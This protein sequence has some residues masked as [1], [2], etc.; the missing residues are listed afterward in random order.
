M[1]IFTPLLAFLLVL[2]TTLMH[3]CLVM[4]G[5]FNPSDPHGILYAQLWDNGQLACEIS[6]TPYY[7]DIMQMSC[8][9]VDHAAWIT[10]D[11]LM[12]AYH[13]HGEDFRMWTG[14]YED[15]EGVFRIL[16]MWFC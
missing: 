2:L 15:D 16:Q 3:A 8:Y 4:L 13:A 6:W 1:K 10:G 7:D 14:I 5:D 12:L 9:G 11:M